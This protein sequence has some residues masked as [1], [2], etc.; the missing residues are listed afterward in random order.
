VY[1]PYYDIAM[2]PKAAIIIQENLEW[3]TSNAMVPKIQALF[4]AVTATQI[5]SAWTIMSKILWKRDDL[6]RNLAMRVLR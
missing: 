6:S 1:T 4:P 3:T 5:Y 2:P